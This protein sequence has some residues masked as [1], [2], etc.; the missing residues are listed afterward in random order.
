M[1]DLMTFRSNALQGLTL[2]RVQPFF[3]SSEDRERWVRKEYER[4]KTLEKRKT[5]TDRRG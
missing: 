3:S 2:L 5:E 1:L 4:H